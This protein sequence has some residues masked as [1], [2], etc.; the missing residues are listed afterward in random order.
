MSNHTWRY[1]LLGIL[2]AAAGLIVIYQVIMIQV[3]PQAEAIKDIARN[4][5]GASVTL[6][7]VRGQIYDRWG[8]LLAGNSTV[9]QIGV[10]VGEVADP[11][12]IATVVSAMTGENFDVMLQRASFDPESG[13]RYSVLTDFVPQDIANRLFIMRDG[14]SAEDSPTGVPVAADPSLRGLALE[15]HLTRFY[16]E[17]ELGA[18]LIGFVTQEGRGYYG[19]EEKY[20]ALLA[21][22]AQEIWMPSD[23]NQIQKAA[24]L[25]EGA[26][27]VLTIDREMQASVQ[28]ILEAA[29]QANGAKS[30]TA[31]VMQPETGEI[32]A[33]SSTPWI[34]LN[35]Y[36]NVHEVF[37]PGMPYNK[38]VSAAFEPGSTYKVLTMAAALDSGLVDPDNVFIDTGIYQIGGI[39]IYNWNG[40][41]WGPQTMIGCMQ[42]S[43]NV[44]L[45][46]L[47][48]EMG[49]PT[50]YDYMRAF[51]IGRMTGIDLAGELPGRL[52]TP[53][54]SDWYEAD[55]GTNSFG[56]GVSVTPIQL[57][58]AVS[59][60]A[61]DG[62]MMTPH[63]LNAVIDRGYQQAYT[64]QIAG[65]PISAETAHTLTEMLSISLEEESSSALVEGYRLAGKTGTAEI[66][67]GGVYSDR[68]NASFIGWGPVD[69][70]KFLIYVWLEEPTS[71]PWGSVVA[72]P[73]FQQ[74]AERVVVLMDIPPDEVRQA[75]TQR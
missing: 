66:P 7:P 54:D 74:I 69:D 26:S 23:P 32:L 46:W 11:N 10:N 24:T 68:T 45:T 71:S 62:M 65:A 67:I 33:M 63:V 52:K 58:M 13:I 36:R 4:Y 16:P 37:P 38:A 42:H 19:I 41:A 21:G 72:A 61:N 29:V 20:N 75:L 14:V 6:Q 53:G 40:G 18:G 1:N 22:Q 56:Q 70:P 12:A 60:V 27:V 17:H 55:L 64:P 48:D 47:A 43:L 9:Y 57:M 51:G 73:I 39:Y 31:I 15:P 30:G 2:L 44:C 34:D 8:H 25:P 5:E 35:E 3:G 28:R 49:A 59:A 50:F